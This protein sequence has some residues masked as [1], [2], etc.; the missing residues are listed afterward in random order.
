MHL[1]VADGPRRNEWHT[2]NMLFSRLT[3]YGILVHRL[4]ENLAS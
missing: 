1:N 2:T 4:V 3:R